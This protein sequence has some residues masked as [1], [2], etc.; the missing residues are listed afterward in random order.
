M[1]WGDIMTWDD[2]MIW[3]DIMTWDDNFR[4]RRTIKGIGEAGG[5]QTS[6]AF[7]PDVI[8]LIAETL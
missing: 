8:F 5:E 6:G 4:Y 3:D 1:T 2:I 7:A